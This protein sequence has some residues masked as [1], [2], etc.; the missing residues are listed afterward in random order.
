MNTLQ[1]ETIDKNMIQFANELDY[2][3]LLPR[4][5][6]TRNFND[7]ERDILRSLSSRSDKNVYLM[8]VLKEKPDLYDNLYYMIKACSPHLADLLIPGMTNKPVPKPE[9]C[10]I[11]CT[12]CN[13]K[14]ISEE[15]LMNHK[16]QYHSNGV[17]YNRTASPVRHTLRVPEADLIDLSDPPP[18]TPKY[19]KNEIITSRDPNGVTNEQRTYLCR[20]LSKFKDMDLTLIVVRLREEGILPGYHVERVLKHDANITR[21]M[22]MLDILKTRSINALIHLHNALLETKQNN[23][24]DIVNICLN[25]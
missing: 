1:K 8:T 5:V 9:T 25:L 11:A 23:L 10:V 14:F 13:L 3:D 24:A 21:V 2:A 15:Y 16:K 18:Y 4:L 17:P 22:D 7:R 12:Q 19:P 20:N 6:A